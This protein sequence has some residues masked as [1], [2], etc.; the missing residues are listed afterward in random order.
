MTLKFLRM[1][2]KCNLTVL[3]VTAPFAI[4]EHLGA[5]EFLINIWWIQLMPNLAV[6][7]VVIGYWITKEKMWE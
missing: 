6:L 4:M 3:S 2:A 7:L 1:W 5:F